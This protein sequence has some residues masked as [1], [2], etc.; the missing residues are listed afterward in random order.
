MLRSLLSCYLLLLFGL[1]EAK[2]K[3]SPKC[4]KGTLELFILQIIIF[5]FVTV[6]HF[7]KQATE[8]LQ[9]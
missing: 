5:F 4:S 9:G 8:A 1:A 2:L 6:L 7:G 3:N